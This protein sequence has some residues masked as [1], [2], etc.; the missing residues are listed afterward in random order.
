MEKSLVLPAG[1]DIRSIFPEECGLS[2][3]INLPLASRRVYE[4]LLLQEHRGEKGVGIISDKDGRFYYR[5]RVGSV[6]EQ[7]FGINFAEKLPG[8]IAIGHNR[9]ATEGSSDSP[10]NVQPLMFKET[11]YGAFAV[12]HNGT[13]A[14]HR[15]IKEQLK[16]EGAVFQSTT[17]SEIF[18]HLIA[19]SE[20]ESFEKAI[21]DALNIVTTAYSLL[22]M[23]HDQ[24]FA[25][26][27]RHGVRPLSI[28]KL[29]EGFLICSE[30]YAFDQYPDAEFIRDIEPGEMIV[31]DKDKDYF[32]SIRYAEA[33]EHFC[34]IE[35]IY[36]SNPRTCYR[37]FMHEDFRQEL[38]A[39]IIR[40]NPD[41]KGDFILPVLDSGKHAAIGMFK[42]SGI[43]YKEYF[44]RI[45][46]PPDANKRSFTSPTDEE[47]IRTAYQ[48]LHL[49]KD[50]IKGRRAIVVDD[51][52]I[53]SITIKIANERLRSA[54]ASEIINCISAPPVKSPCMLGMDYQ[55]SKQLAAASQS[56]ED[57]R[58]SIGADKLIYLSFEGLQDVVNRTYKCGICS[59]CFGGK[60]PA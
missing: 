8:K 59:G 9:Y 45:H 31:F 13:L 23:T 6:Q 2:A 32:R 55:D 48:K 27:D 51:T 21:V 43:P 37:R 53:R 15:P 14:N 41:L 29:G 58:R 44:L 39:Q 33:P 1:M 20:Q 4:C 54:G 5:K 18:G 52:I 34:I 12:A 40:E 22:I 60:Y 24:F 3:A 16:K 30:S 42:E 57:I 10:N 26:R 19:R 50:K 36:F 47:R 17:D 46:N 11:K 28:A 25:I 35:G 56:I 49:R 7:F 38:G